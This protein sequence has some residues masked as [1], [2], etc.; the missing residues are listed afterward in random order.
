MV[1][2]KVRQRC[3]VD[4]RAGRRAK[5]AF[6]D[7]VSIGTG[8]GAERVEVQ[9]E[10]TSEQRGD[11][12]EVEQRLHQRLVVGNGV[13]D[14]DGQ[15]AEGAGAEAA[16]IDLGSVD[17]PIRIDRLR[18]LEDRARHRFRRRASVADVVLDAEVARRAA[19]V[20]ARRQDDPAVR[21]ALADHARRRRCRQDAI[22]A[23]DDAAEAVR[24]RHLQDRLHGDVVVVTTVATDDERRARRCIQAVEDRL[25]EVLEV[26]RLTEHR[27]LLA[28]TRRPRRLP[29][30]RSR[31]H[32][33]DVR[34]AMPP[35]L[36]V[37]GGD[38]AAPVSG[39]DAAAPANMRS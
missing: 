8:D 5:R 23:D 30:E 28:Q 33:A 13:D 26:V 18:P 19:L 35:W 1:A 15:I 4:D 6:E 22:A 36:V 39:G 2:T 31:R 12:I 3:A 11:A 16:E 25:H 38:A 24:G 34:H 14:L 7:G 9:A 32:G 10:A 37:S 21:L 20:V 29:I 17:D 27:H